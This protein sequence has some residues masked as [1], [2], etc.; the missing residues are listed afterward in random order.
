M[1]IFISADMEGATGVVQ[2][3]Q[4]TSA[5][6]EYEFGCRMQ[7]HDVKAVVNGALEAGAGEILINDSH[8][9]MTNL[10]IDEL[11]FD[12]RV[13]LL[14]GSSKRLSMVEGLEQADAAFFVCYHA[15]AGTENA[16]LDHTMSAGAVHSVVLNGVEVGE[17]G[18]N[19]AVLA[20]K[21]IPLALVT[22]DSAV[23]EEASLLMGDGLITACVKDA[24]SR[25]SADG[26]LPKDSGRLLKKAARKAVERIHAGISPCMNIGDGDFDLRI[27]FNDSLRCD[28]ASK[29]PGAER[30]G[31]RTVR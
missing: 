14:T 5:D 29:V 20:Q 31:G 10:D 11:S 2:W 19:A 6:R 17:T 13:R 3:A 12:S 30:I 9:G 26:L 23:C 4:V 27:T 1:R 15:K 28:R 16:I 18:L 8:D 22:G 25:T 24:H 21:K 7:M